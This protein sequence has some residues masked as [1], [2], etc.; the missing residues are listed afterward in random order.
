MAGFSVR[1]SE[2]AVDLCRPMNARSYVMC[3][4]RG[5]L[6]SNETGYDVSR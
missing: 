2:R 1:E 4:R 6:C 3:N 5:F